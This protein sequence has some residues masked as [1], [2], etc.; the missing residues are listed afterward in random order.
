[1][2]ETENPGAGRTA[3]GAEL[4][5]AGAIERSENSGSSSHRQRLPDRRNS[6]IVEF[7]HEG[8]H[9]RA[10]VSRFADGSLAEI[11]L[12]ATRPGSGAAV[13]AQDSAILASLAMQH[14]VPV[15]TIGSAIKG[16]IS[17]ALS[18]FAKDMA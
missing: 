5:I 18:M 14:G 1:M 11:F 10:S 15:S 4:N 2:L 13:N 17:R 9:Y 12:D 8:H 6:E 7:V 3:H 16:P